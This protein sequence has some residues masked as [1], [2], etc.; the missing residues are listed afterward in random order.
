MHVVVEPED[1]DDFFVN[2]QASNQVLWEDI[3]R[4]NWECII[5]TAQN[6]IFRSW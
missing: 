2:G 4:F 1:K 5:A 6:T 3:L